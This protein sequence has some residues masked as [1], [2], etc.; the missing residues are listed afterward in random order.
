MRATPACV[1]HPSPGPGTRH[2]G[3]LPPGE[4]RAEVACSE[5]LWGLALVPT[6]DIGRGEA[7]W[8]WRQQ[9]SARLP[10]HQDPTLGT[11]LPK[12]EAVKLEEKMPR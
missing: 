3:A 12:V 11:W 10:V 4:V 5:S 2:G 1:A 9:A 6:R 7:V 8:P